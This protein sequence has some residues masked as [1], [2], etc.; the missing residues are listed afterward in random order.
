[1]T[2][3]SLILFDLQAMLCSL[4][5]SLHDMSDSISFLRGARLPS[6]QAAFTGGVAMFYAA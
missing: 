4:I 6:S 1:M 3:L 2:C 5:T